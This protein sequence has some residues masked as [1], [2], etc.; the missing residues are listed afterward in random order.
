MDVANTGQTDNPA[1]QHR[2]DEAEIRTLLTDRH[3][4]A[5]ET[6]TADEVGRYAGDA[7]LYDA[8]PPYKIV[9][10]EAIGRLREGCWVHSPRESQSP[11]RD[12]RLSISGDMAVF[13]GLLQFV[14]PDKN[15]PA[16]K[17][18][19]RITVC[20]QRNNSRWEVFHEHISLPFHPL[21]NTASF[22][23]TGQLEGREPLDQWTACSDPEE[24]TPWIADV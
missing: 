23:T 11:P 13:N 9:G 18:W 2:R 17:G 19:M 15:H 5:R 22:I 3:R 4:V 10:A 16:D 24:G 1:E 7:V 12:G 8:C 20:L 21:T 6:D 14:P